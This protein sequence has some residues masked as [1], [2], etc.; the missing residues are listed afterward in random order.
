MKTLKDLFNL[1]N[2]DRPEMKGDSL[3]E[4]YN[5]IIQK[6]PN[7]LTP[8]D[9]GFLFRQD[10][11]S[12]FALEQIVKL[13]MSNPLAE[14]DMYQIPLLNS[15]DIDRGFTKKEKESI[16]AAMQSLKKPKKVANSSK[17]R[18]IRKNTPNLCAKSKKS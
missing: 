10:I 15:L 8:G 14:D 1:E 16:K 11:V 2:D 4:N 17:E 9:L 3:V 7:E 13:L 18:M 5:R 6:T 12:D